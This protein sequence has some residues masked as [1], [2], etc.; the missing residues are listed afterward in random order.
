VPTRAGLSA[1][2]AARS[3]VVERARRYGSPALRGKDS[4]NRA[5]EPGRVGRDS[6]SSGRTTGVVVRRVAPLSVLK[7]SVLF[8][9]SAGL[10]LLV[11]GVLLWSGAH[12]VGLIGNLESFMGDIGFSDFRLEGDQVLKAWLIVGSVLVVGGSFANLLM[13]M[14]YNLLADVV[15][16][17]KLLLAEDDA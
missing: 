4:G 9:L 3:S 10:V 1:I 7:V 2:S 16:G 12:A 11:A 13:A 15:G 5:A 6:P 17:V 14:L 8:Y